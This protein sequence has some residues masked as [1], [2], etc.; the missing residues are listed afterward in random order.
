M[1]AK[2]SA[3]SSTPLMSVSASGDRERALE[4]AL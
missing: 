1:A 3:K 2:N 4:T